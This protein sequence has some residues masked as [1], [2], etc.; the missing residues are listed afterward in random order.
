MFES[1]IARMGGRGRSPAPP[2]YPALAPF[3]FAT[4]HLK[5]LAN[6]CQLSSPMTM[7]SKEQGV[8][9]EK[10]PCP[11]C[12]DTG[13]VVEAVT[14]VTSEVAGAPDIFVPCPV[15]KELPPQK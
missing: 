9:D 3:A 4:Q 8:E 12:N 10:K 11:L 5:N 1:S 13:F 7:M 6:V 14:D 2:V 15:Q